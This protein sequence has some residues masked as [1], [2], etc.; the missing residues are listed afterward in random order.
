M[1]ARG[2]S[3]GTRMKQAGAEPPRADIPIVAL[4][5]PTAG[6][7][8]AAALAI[9]EAFGA[10]IINADSMQVYRDLAI[11]TARPGPDQLA[12]VPHRLYGCLSGRERCSAGRW[13]SLADAE[14]GS[15]VASGRLPLLVGGTGFYLRALEQG[16]A[17]LPEVAE[18]LRARI[19]ARCERIGAQAFHRELAAR[20]PVMAGRLHPNDRQRLIRA[21]EVLEATGRSLADWQAGTADREGG[22]G[23]PGR[24]EILHLALVPPRD[25]LYAACDTRFQ[26]MIAQGALAEVRGLLAE[27]L[28]PRLPIM[29]ALGVPELTAHLRGD[30]SL[31]DAIEAAQQATRRY[32]KRQLTW[33]RTQTERKNP[34]Y[35]HVFEQFSK[36]SEQ[37]I[38]KIIRDFLLTPPD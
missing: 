3:R 32:A 25:R 31:Q 21:M 6:G 5:G 16:L 11:L 13:R 35:F 18:D 1:A 22:R 24:R 37:K 7:K 29:K 33:L 26:D 2:T 36:S 38:F 8:S 34:A 19:A 15:A 23:S 4:S 17:D 30:C 9:A 14:I 12:R 27:D 10:T 20:D 28:D